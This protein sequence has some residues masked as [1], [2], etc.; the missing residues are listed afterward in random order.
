MSVLYFATVLGHRCDVIST[1]FSSFSLFGRRRRRFEAESITMTRP[2]SAIQLLPTPRKGKA[3]WREYRP[4]R[5][6]NGVTCMAVH[7]QESKVTAVTASVNVGAAADPRELSGLAH[8]AEH[9]CF[10]GSEKYPGENEVRNAAVMDSVLS[11]FD[12]L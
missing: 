6:D 12:K 8:F 4:F 1:E 9:M 2:P 10:L 5:L 3:D 7:D 11:F